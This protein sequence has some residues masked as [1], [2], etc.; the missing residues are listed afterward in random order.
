M[1]EKTFEVTVIRA[2]T[3]T[4]RIKVSA[5]TAKEAEDKAID[6]A[7][8]YDFE[9]EKTAEYEVEDCVEVTA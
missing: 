1:A 8:G 4:A 6:E 5:A 7:G 3:R 9:L 2:A